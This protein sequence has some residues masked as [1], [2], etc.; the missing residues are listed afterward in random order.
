MRGV[1]GQIY[2]GSKE[3]THNKKIGFKSGDKITIK[4]NFNNSKI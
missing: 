1:K 3:I 2:S 4:T